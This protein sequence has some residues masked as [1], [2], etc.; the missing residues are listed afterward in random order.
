MST[1][2]HLS[3]NKKKTE[4]LIR[5]AKRSMLFRIREANDQ[6]LKCVPG[7]E[8]IK[9]GLETMVNQLVQNLWDWEKEALTAKNWNCVLLTTNMIYFERTIEAVDYETEKAKYLLYLNGT[10]TIQPTDRIAVFPA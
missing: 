1:L 5:Q 7:A 9:G 10:C 2:Q 4:I 3:K 8:T 6:F